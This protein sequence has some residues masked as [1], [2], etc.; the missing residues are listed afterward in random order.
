MHTFFTIA[1]IRTP[2]AWLDQNKQCGARIVISKSFGLQ[3]LYRGHRTAVQA[4][5]LVALAPVITRS[6]AR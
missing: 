1:N 5:L 6:T 4:A 3:S 2:N